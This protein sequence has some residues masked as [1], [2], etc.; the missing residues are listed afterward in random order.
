[1]GKPDFPIPLPGE[2]QTPPPAVGTRGNRVSPIP[3]PGGV[4][5]APTSGWDT[6]KPGFPNPPAWGGASRSHQRLG[7]GETGFP[8]PPAWGVPDIPNGGWEVGK[9]RF[10]IFPP[11]GCQTLPTAVGKWGNR[12][13]PSSCLGVAR[14]PQQRLGHGETGFPHLPPRKKLFS[15]RRCAAQPQRGVTQL[16]HQK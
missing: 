9:P 14:R 5:A 6:G 13:S 12:V 7:H 3:L 10:P 8:R 11:G 1:M 4:L 16:L 15:S 2:C